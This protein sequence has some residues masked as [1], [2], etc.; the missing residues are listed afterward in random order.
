MLGGGS[1]EAALVEDWHVLPI[2][3][4][5]GMDRYRL[6]VEIFEA[7]T[8]ISHAALQSW[9]TSLYLCY[10]ADITSWKLSIL[11]IE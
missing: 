1:N 5:V 3:L 6:Y 9:C 7:P 10:A 11:I 8:K 2:Y 4:Y